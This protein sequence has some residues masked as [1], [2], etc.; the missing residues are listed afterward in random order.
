MSIAA[1]GQIALRALPGIGR[2]LGSMGNTAS[3]RA[4]IGGLGAGVGAGAVSSFFGG[5]GDDSD[6]R[7]RRRSRGFSAR[8]IRQARKLVRLA[9][10]F[11]CPGS[12][13]RKAG[14]KSCR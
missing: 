4:A 2:T 12:K 10:D 14:K 3:G 13:S 7:P 11:S 5:G 1:L 9:N 6:Y 8:D